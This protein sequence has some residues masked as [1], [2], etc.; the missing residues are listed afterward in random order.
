MPGDDRGDCLHIASLPIG[1]QVLREVGSKRLGVIAK[2][3]S[4]LIAPLQQHNDGRV[5]RDAWKGDI[6]LFLECKR[7]RRQ[8]S[9]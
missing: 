7:L 8:A 9:W 5:L 3:S 1:E 2:D 6:Q 4:G